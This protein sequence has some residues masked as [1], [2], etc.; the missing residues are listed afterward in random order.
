MVSL[1]GDSL[2]DVP[3]CSIKGAIGT[4]LG[5]APAIQIASAVLGQRNGLIPPTVNWDYPDPSCPLNLSKQA[6]SI[7]HNVTLLN[8]HGVGGVNASM[9]LEK[10]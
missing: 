6:R 3:A 4:P 1:F 9:V 7:E 2:A 5:A 10:C 8:A